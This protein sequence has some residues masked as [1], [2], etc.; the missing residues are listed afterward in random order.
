MKIRLLIVLIIVAAAGRFLPAQVKMMDESDLEIKKLIEGFMMKDIVS[1]TVYRYDIDS[2]VVGT[3]AEKISKM[4][5]DMNSR[6]FTV[7]ELY[8]NYSKTVI[9]FNDNNDIYDIGIYYAD[10]SLMSRVKTAYES[11]GKVKEKIYYFGNTYT[12]KIENKYSSGNLI[13]QEYTDSLGKIQNYSNL[14]YDNAGKVIEEDKYN[15]FDSLEIT[16]SYSYD[17]NGNCTEE[18]MAYPSS[19]I[20]LKT[21]KKYDSNNRITEKMNYGAGEKISSRNIYK[22]NESGKLSEESIYSIDD[23]LTIK[24]EYFY[25]ENG[26]K[27]SWKYTDAL[28]DIEYLYK[29]VYN[30][31]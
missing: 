6:L 13:R 17:G 11:D 25:D 12:F 14:F 9:K 30:E 31:K 26:N 10:N 21:V 22:Y 15:S 4:A 20:I 23:K 1:S 16:Y 2:G 5:L 18:L 3:E 19:K 27:T 24:Y 29:I 7:T 28:E 8:P